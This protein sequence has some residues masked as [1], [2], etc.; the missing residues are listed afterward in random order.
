M[1]D[2]DRTNQ[3]KKINNK[4]YT[5]LSGKWNTAVSLSEEILRKIS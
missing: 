2:D 1:K 4:I 3:V 5:I